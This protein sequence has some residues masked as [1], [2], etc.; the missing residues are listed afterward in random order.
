ML[1]VL[2][3][4]FVYLGLCIIYIMS[5]GCWLNGW[6]SIEGVYFFIY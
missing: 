1:I 4:M 5:W 6:V 2:L 3:S